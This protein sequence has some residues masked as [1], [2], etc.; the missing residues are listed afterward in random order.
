LPILV[1][2]AWALRQNLT[3]YDA[4]YVALAQTLDCE[5]IT[6]DRRIGAAPALGV[7]IKLITG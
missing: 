5:L 4:L 7:P 1:E 2:R 6:A 3:L